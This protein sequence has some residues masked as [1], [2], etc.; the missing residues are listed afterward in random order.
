MR[1]R[2]SHQSKG[3]DMSRVADMEIGSSI[4]CSRHN[5]P[6]ILSARM[7]KM[8]CRICDECIAKYKNAHGEENRR[9]VRAEK[10]AAGKWLNRESLDGEVWRPIQGYSNYESSTFGRVRSKDRR[11]TLGRIAFGR[12]MSQ[13]VSNS[14]YARVHVRADSSSVAQTVA[15]HILVALAFHGLRPPTHDVAHN[16][17]NPRNNAPTNLR[18]ATRKENE[19]DKDL[20]GTRFHAIGGLNGGAKL[21][22]DAVRRIRTDLERGVPASTIQY[23]HGVS[24]SC[25]SLIK[26]R[27]TWKHI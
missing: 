27:R 19:A 10:I 6:A 18:Y 11:D 24:Q 14:G 3:E 21:T 4:I 7:K 2:S 12:I 20:H 25:V 23:E 16:D 13:H 17:G 5:G 15:V 22:A 9:S 26:T 1:H 8:Q